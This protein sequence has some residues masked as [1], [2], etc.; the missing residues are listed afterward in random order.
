M[1]SCHLFVGCHFGIEWYEATKADT[2]N[3]NIAPVY[4]Y[5]YF[6][7]DLGCLRIQKC[8]EINND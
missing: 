3:P 6:I 2:N 7:I 1:W 4:K 5:E 8:K